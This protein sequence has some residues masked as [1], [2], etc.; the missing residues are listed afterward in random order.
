[1][2]RPTNIYPSERKLFLLLGLLAIAQEE[3]YPAEEQDELTRRV[4]LELSARREM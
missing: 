1:M 2:S 4:I 3:S